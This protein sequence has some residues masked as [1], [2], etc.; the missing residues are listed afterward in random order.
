MILPFKINL[1]PNWREHPRM[2][3]KLDAILVHRIDSGSDAKGVM[4]AFH[5]AVPGAAEVTGGQMP[6]HFIVEKDGAVVQC[7]PLSVKA[8]HGWKWNSHSVGVAAIG[9][10]TI[11]PPAASQWRSALMLCFLLSEPQGWE[12]HGHTEV[13]MSTKDPRKVC[14]G[15]LWPMDNFRAEMKTLSINAT[16]IEDFWHY[17]QC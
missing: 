2:R 17:V 11:H 3:Q 5:G 14:P 1:D 6:Y 4:D 10:F 8:P 7:L 15:H 9:N 16:D 13:A 12:V